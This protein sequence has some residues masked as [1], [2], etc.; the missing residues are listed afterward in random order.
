MDLFLLYQNIFKVKNNKQNRK[1][2]E[3]SRKDMVTKM[4]NLVFT[5]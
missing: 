2:M 1:L 3:Y 5:F 4:I